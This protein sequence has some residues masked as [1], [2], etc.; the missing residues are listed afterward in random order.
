MSTG[1]AHQSPHTGVIRL[2]DVLATN[3]RLAR[4]P[5]LQSGETIMLA[6]SDL[7]EAAL[8]MSLGYFAA[9][10]TVIASHFPAMV[11]AASLA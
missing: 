3:L 9:D 11:S 7:T 1:Q 5:S 4:F 2:D 10:I 8:G 6:Q